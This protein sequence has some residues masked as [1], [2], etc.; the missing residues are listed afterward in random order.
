MKLIILSFFAFINCQLTTV[1]EGGDTNHT[2]SFIVPT[3]RTKLLE[4]ILVVENL[5]NDI[6]TNFNVP[7]VLHNNSNIIQSMDSR[8][9]RP[10]CLYTHNYTNYD[11]ISYERVAVSMY[12]SLNLT[13]EDQLLSLKAKHVYFLNSLQ[14]NLIVIPLSLRSIIG[15]TG[16]KT[17]NCS[18]SINFT[19]FFELELNVTTAQQNDTLQLNPIVLPS[20]KH[21]AFVYN[22][23]TLFS[24]IVSNNICTVPNIVG[25]GYVFLVNDTIVNDNTILSGPALLNVYKNTTDTLPKPDDGTSVGIHITTTINLML[26]TFLLFI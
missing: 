7:L 10:P 23:T 24:D 5:L 20:S 11:L 16:D 14:G 17:I 19:S 1:T 9:N 18:V 6:Y 12:N 13:G 8:I 25:D 3:N 15:L 2:D 22:T 4:Y 21:C 26:T